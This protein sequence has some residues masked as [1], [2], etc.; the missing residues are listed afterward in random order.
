VRHPL[1]ERQRRL[2]SFAEF[3]D[4]IAFPEIGAVLSEF[5]G[6]IATLLPLA[7]NGHLLMLGALAQSFQ[8]IPRSA[9]MLPATTLAQVADWGGLVFRYGLLLS[10]PLLVAMMIAASSSC[11]AAGALA[12]N[13]K[14]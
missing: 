5:F 11:W 2:Y 3:H 12:S 9:S 4:G 8:T 10:L 13:S 14:S 7:G 6:V 1:R